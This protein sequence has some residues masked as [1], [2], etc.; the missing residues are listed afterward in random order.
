MHTLLNV[1]P[2]NN[3]NLTHTSLIVLQITE[4]SPYIM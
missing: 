3:A 4:Y 2:L 1:K